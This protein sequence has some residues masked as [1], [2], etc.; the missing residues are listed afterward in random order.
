MEQIA[1]IT[2]TM[3]R[4][5]ETGEHQVTA[6]FEGAENDLLICL[7]ATVNRACDSAGMTQLDFAKLCN[8]DRRKDEPAAADVR[9]VRWIPVKE[10]LPENGVNVL[11]WYEYYHWSAERVLPEYGIGYCINGMW[12]G[13]VSNGYDCKVLYWMPLPEPPAA[14][15]E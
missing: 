6:D 15:G 7:A 8:I 11:C 1:K 2:I 14:K 10:Q 3:N 9:P 13:E 4:D 5:A 12:G